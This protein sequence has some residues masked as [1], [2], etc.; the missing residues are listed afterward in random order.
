[1]RKNNLRFIDREENVTQWAAKWIWTHDPTRKPFHSCYFRKTFFVE[2]PNIAARIHCAADSKYRLWVNGD[3]IGFG[4]ARGHPEHP[5]YDTRTITLKKGLNTLA[6]LVEHYSVP[7][8]IFASVR[9][10]LI[11]QIE[12]KGRVLAATDCTWKALTADAYR[13]LPG[14]LFPEC[15]DAR[16]EPERWYKNSFDDSS[17]PDAVE[18]SGAG[19]FRRK[20]L[21]P[22]PI[23]LIEEKRLPPFRILNA[24]NCWSDNRKCWTDEDNIGEDLW[25]MKLGPAKTGHLSPALKFPCAFPDRLAI[26]LGAGEG[27]YLVLDSGMETLG[28]PEISVSGHAGMIVDLGYSECL[29]NNRVPTLWQSPS[30]KQSDR[31]I[32]RDGT[33]R[34]RINQPR[35]FRYMIMRFVNN[36]EGARA[37][38][39]NSVEVYEALYPAKASGS[40]RCSD[41]ILNR[42]YKLSARTVNLCMEDS[43]T[44]CPWRERSQWAGDAQPEAI[45]NY[46]CFGAYDLARKA[47]LEFTSG[48]TSEGWIPGVFPISKPFNLP[49]WG[50]RIPVIVWEYYLYTGDRKTLIA[51]YE[52]VRRQMDWLARHTDRNGLFVCRDGWNFVDWTGVDDR[53]ADGA[54]QGWY[55]Q[56]LLYCAKIA[57]ELKEQEAA[58]NYRRRAA[59]LRKSI[60]GLYWSP[61]K[62]AFRKYRP[63]SPNLPPGASTELIG[64]HENFLFSLLGIGSARQRRL[65]LDAMKGVTGFY[66]PN[67]GDYQSAHLQEH[68]GNYIGEEIIRIGSPFWSFYALLS[69]MEAGRDMAAIEY[70]RLC[71]GLMLEFGATSCWE[72]WDRHTSL[73]HGWSAAPAMILPAYV[74]GVKP[75]RP[76]FRLFEIRPRLCDIIWA[77]GSVPSPAGQISVSWRISGLHNRRWH[78]SVK[79]PDGLSAVLVVPVEFSLGQNNR[80]FH[81]KEGQHNFSFHSGIAK[82]ANDQQRKS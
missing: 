26:K 49:T 50:M 48:N 61:D 19:L 30:L 75:L 80:R 37:V 71:W 68:H 25:N 53:Y 64:Q 82:G 44:D 79:V 73:C 9:G 58:L 23:P 52:G 11:C 12:S 46:Y 16:I 20:N 8:G 35:G 34:H 32:L 22:R 5:Y 18:I 29:W 43:F 55:L 14:N 33:T 24:G 13:P 17:W 31:I 15:F 67:I 72:M 76:G 2:R 77:Q 63:A 1:M 41:D 51:S 7:T 42:I 28:S 47:V 10:A 45:F 66:I 40:F 56:A 62:K 21:A 74:L 59:L 69:L 57:Q 54:V 6:F 81:L 4:P 60:A 36:S 39:L 3:Y 78:I 65:A 70:I 27:F 38:V